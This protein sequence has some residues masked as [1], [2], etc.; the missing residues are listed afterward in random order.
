MKFIKNKN[1]IDGEE[2]LFV[3]RLHW[4]YI[5]KPF[6]QALPYFLV[7]FVLW[8]V[9]NNS[10]INLPYVKDIAN[11]FF[12]NLFLISIVFYLL[13]IVIRLFKY[14]NTEFAVSSR[15]FVMKT[16]VFRI[17]VAEI[18]TDRI[19]TIYCA[20]GLWDRVFRCGTIYF[21]GV[22]GRMP[23]F[24]MIHS[25]FAIRRKVVEIIEKNKRVTV[26]NGQ[27]P[28]PP[29]AAKDPKAKDDPAYLHGNFVRIMQ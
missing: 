29:S 24:F 5:F 16:G 22:G 13:V 1:L 10:G 6:F 7:L 20:Q 28:K 11:N 26:V 17:V 19:E 23:R 3:P 4:F 18:P 27:F 2:Y 15:R 12:R 21:G 14:M 8:I 9:S 25:P